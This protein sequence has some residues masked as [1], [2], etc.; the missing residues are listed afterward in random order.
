MANFIEKSAKTKEEAIELALLELGLTEAD[1]EIEV[2]EEGS[3]GFLG[4]GGR[5][6]V[7]RVS[8]TDST[9]ARAQKFLDGIF[10]ILGEEVA[11]D[12]K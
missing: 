12:V 2:I 7:V 5:D 1:V 10:S 3:K 9:S 4:I 8:Y 6:A 11:V